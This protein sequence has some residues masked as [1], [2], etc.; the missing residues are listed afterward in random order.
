MKALLNKVAEMAD[1]P[2]WPPNYDLCVSVLSSD[3][4][5]S[6]IVPEMDGVMK[7]DPPEIYGLDGQP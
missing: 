1:N 6:D 3:F 5:L 2:D 7:R 4:S